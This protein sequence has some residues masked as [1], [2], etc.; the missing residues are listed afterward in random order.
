VQTRKALRQAK[1]ALITFAASYADLRDDDEKGPG[2]LP[3]PSAS[4]DGDPTSC[5]NG[6]TTTHRSGWLPFKILGIDDLRDGSGERLWYVVSDNYKNTLADSYVLNSETPGLISLVDEGGV[7]QDDIVALVIAPGAPVCAQSGRPSFDSDD[8][9]L[10][11]EEENAAPVNGLFVA[12]GDAV[13]AG[14][15]EVEFNDVVEPVTRAELMAAVEARVAND[16]RAALES[17]RSPPTGTDCNYPWDIPDSADDYTGTCT[18]AYPWLAPF[19]DPRRSGR[20]GASVSGY[21]LSG[22]HDSSTSVS[23]LTD[24]SADFVTAGVVAGDT[25]WNV[26][27]G[28]FGTVVSL[29]ATTLTVDALAGGD[30]DDFQDGDEYYVET[31]APAL[32]AI[33]SGAA[34]VGSSGVSLDAA[35]DLEAFGVVAGD[36]VDEVDTASG[37]IVA[38]AR[39]VSVDGDDVT[40]DPDFGAD[41]QP[42]DT[43]RVRSAIGVAS[44]GSAGTTLEDEGIDF[45]SALVGVNAGDRV[46][47]LT[48]G[49]Q[50]VVASVAGQTLTA[51]SLYGGMDNDFDAGDNYALVRQLPQ[52][53]TRSGQLP[54]HEFGKPFVTDFSVKWSLLPSNDNTV[55]TSAPGAASWYSTAIS[56][57][58]ERSTLYSDAPEGDDT[59]PDAVPVYTDVAC[60]WAGLRV[61]H[62]SGSYND[63]AFLTGTVDSVSTSGAIVSITDAGTRFNYSGVRSG[64]KIRNV[65]QGL[66]GIVHAASSTTQNVVSAVAIDD[67]G[68]LFTAAD[69]DEFRVQVAS[70]SLPSSGSYTA[71]GATAA[72]QAC[73][74]SADFSSI[75]AGDTI[76]LNSPTYGNPVGLITGVPN[77]N[78]VTYT[79]LQ[80]GTATSIALGQNFRIHYDFVEERRWAVRVRMAGNSIA[81][82]SDPGIRERSVCQGFGSDCASQ[83]A[84]ALHVLDNSNPVVEFTDFDADGNQLGTASV[85]I[86]EYD[87]GV[88][89]PTG[90]LLVSGIRLMMDVDRDSDEIADP[91]DGNLPHW[92]LR[93]RWHEYVFVS[94]SEALSPTAVAAKSSSDCP[95]D[96]VCVSVRM[97]TGI[98]RSDRKAVVAIAG[99]ELADFDRA[100][101]A[102]GGTFDGLFNDYFEDMNADADTGDLNFEQAESSDTFNDQLSAVTP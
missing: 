50:G 43:Y 41:F 74:S 102:P 21:G 6:V 97:P 85:V 14:S 48:D 64:A 96:A 2:Y 44:G 3:C 61:A 39:V 51:T 11:L 34:G 26:T 88:T 27:D 62:C 68:A 36:I 23:V 82:S 7:A 87:P 69:G 42:G 66:D 5:G 78:C 60:I 84:D 83:S 29:T 20:Y 92:F 53:G 86:P 22:R 10:Y 31:A 95:T 19:G 81:T 8:A 101:G 1:Q 25:V 65:T 45:G 13:C 93:N 9:D 4:N 100:S 47:N 67:G 72:N 17:W 63:T 99:A 75:S 37:A 59:Y 18:G 40:L 24:S 90:S 73:S 33:F 94:F 98:T 30:G 35:F 56:D 91:Q 32:G 15:G 16:V 55:S 49:S 79:D 12:T 38:S 28:S 57:W 80:G 54:I 52:T 77:A 71:D 89:E 46:L 58:I 70:K 76:R